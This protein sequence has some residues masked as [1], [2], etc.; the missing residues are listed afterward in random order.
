MEK[1]QKFLADQVRLCPEQVNKKLRV[2]RPC[3]WYTLAIGNRK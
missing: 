1:E 2:A 3:G